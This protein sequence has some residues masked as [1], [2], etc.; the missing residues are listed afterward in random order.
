MKQHHRRPVVV[1]VI[2]VVVVVVVVAVFS[3]AERTEERCVKRT[4]GYTG[5]LRS[6][7]ETRGLRS[8][9]EPAKPGG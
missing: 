7:A 1:V 5:R 8:S 4:A 6:T 3:P 9:G 2:V